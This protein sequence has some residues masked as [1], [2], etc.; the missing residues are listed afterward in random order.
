MKICGGGGGQG[1]IFHNNF[2]YRSLTHLFFSIFGW[3]DHPCIKGKFPA[4]GGR[5]KNNR[6]FAFWGR[7]L[8][9]ELCFWLFGGF[10]HV[11][12]MYSCTGLSTRPLILKSTHFVL[13]SLKDTIFGKMSSF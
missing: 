1:L 11:F 9:P 10:L 4:L 2:T 8:V 5:G 12:M 6:I 13:F 7:I 3:G